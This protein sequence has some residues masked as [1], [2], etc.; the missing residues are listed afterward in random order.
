MRTLYTLLQNVLVSLYSGFYASISSLFTYLT[1]LILF[2]TPADNS[3][4]VLAMSSVSGQ[5]FTASSS[6]EMQKPNE[7]VERT[8]SSIT[9]VA[10]SVKTTEIEKKTDDKITDSQL[11]SL[12]KKFG[13]VFDFALPEIVDS[14]TNQADLQKYILTREEMI[15]LDFGS[16]RK[17]LLSL[18]CK[19]PFYVLEKSEFEVGSLLYESTLTP[20]ETA[21]MKGCCRY[22]N[23][24]LMSS[25][26][27]T[28]DEQKKPKD[29]VDA[30]DV[31]YRFISASAPLPINFRNW[32]KLL[33]DKVSIVVMLTPYVES[34][35]KKA[36]VYLTPE[37][38][39]FQNHG[40]YCVLSEI[41][42]KDDH[43]GIAV[44]KVTIKKRHIVVINETND[45]KQSD[46]QNK[47]DAPFDDDPRVIYHI[48][49]T[50]WSDHHIPDHQEFANLLKVYDSFVNLQKENGAP[51]SM[52]TLVH[53]SAGVGRT[54]TFIAIQ[55]IFEMI[56]NQGFNKIFEP[57]SEHQSKH[58]T[59]DYQDCTIN[60]VDVVA[61]MRRCRFGMVQTYEQFEFIYNYIRTALV[62]EEV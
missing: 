22:S 59:T 29:F 62:N 60:L 7:I 50:Q 31:G 39:E 58:Q 41:V 56:K 18:G 14:N 5:N 20:L 25:S 54:G 46:T 48:H 3:S 10:S 36:D 53:C 13:N 27:I 61:Q 43:G 47:D 49:Y 19:D 23:R 37:E 6:V 8:T 16:W 44:T 52:K 11:D 12:V 57:Q 42:L 9:K 40:D 24:F 32:F 21:N 15:C 17:K 35:R 34:G 1:G 26:M 4:P 33:H 38:K 28:V 30:S 2:R 55:Y 51:S 45:T